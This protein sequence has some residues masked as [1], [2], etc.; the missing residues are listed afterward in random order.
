MASA[1]LPRPTSFGIAIPIGTLALSGVF[2]AKAVY[3][4]PVRWALALVPVGLLFSFIG[5]KLEIM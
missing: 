3:G 4:S 2:L 5:V 1:L